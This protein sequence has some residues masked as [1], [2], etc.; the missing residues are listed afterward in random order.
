MPII[1]LRRNQDN[2]VIRFKDTNTI[3]TGNQCCCDSYTITISDVSISGDLHETDCISDGG[4]VGFYWEQSGEWTTIDT[5]NV[6]PLDPDS[7]CGQCGTPS[8]NCSFTVNAVLDED[9]VDNWCVELPCDP[10]CGR[11][12][13]GLCNDLFYAYAGLD[14][15]VCNYGISHV[16]AYAG[17]DIESGLTICCGACGDTCSCC[18]CHSPGGHCNE[19]NDCECPWCGYT[20]CWIVGDAY[21][22]FDGS[23]ASWSSF[24]DLVDSPRTVSISLYIEDISDQYCGGC[25]CADCDGDDC[26]PTFT[27]DGLYYNSNLTLTFT[28]E[29]EKN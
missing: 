13:P 28:I 6:D 7:G 25:G 12:Y 23:W 17:S 21:D 8:W 29:A 5:G 16:D 14:V 20:T 9:T 1:P 2:T 10:E 22:E 18:D 15:V 19:T 24:D 4:D 3:A 27:E 26:W 11:V